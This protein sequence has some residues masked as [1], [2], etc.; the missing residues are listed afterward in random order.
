M[1]NTATAKAIGL[2]ISR[3]QSVEVCRLIRGKNIDWVKKTL[4][5]VIKEKIAVPYKRYNDN[6]GHRCGM[7]AGRYPMKTCKHILSLVNSVEKN[8]K[9]KGLN[10]TDFVVD[11]S[12]HKGPKA[13]RYGRKPGKSA[14][15]T[16]LF[17]AL[18][19]AKNELKNKNRNI[20]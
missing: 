20:K 2:P 16:N 3:K 9:F 4:V 6:V 18:V 11:I 17:V 1:E 12:A 14:K 13:V 19:Q 5:D 8:A 15:R 7:A 10:T